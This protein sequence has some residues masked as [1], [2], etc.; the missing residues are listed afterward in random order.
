MDPISL[1]GLVGWI[2]VHVLALAAAWGTRVAAR[3]GIELALQVCFLAAMAAVTGT[4]WICHHYDVGLWMPSAVV[5]VAMVLTAVTDVRKT[6]ES[7]SL[8]DLSAG[9]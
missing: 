6:Y 3:P 1:G 7:A 2:A 4:G 8:S 5:L 9:R